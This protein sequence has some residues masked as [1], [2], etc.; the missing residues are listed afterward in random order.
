MERL[1]V[2]GDMNNDETHFVGNKA[3]GRISKRVLQE[4]KARLILWKTNISYPLIRV[5]VR[6][7]FRG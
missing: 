3:K 2:Q 7:R 5:H 1:P 4:K 6:V